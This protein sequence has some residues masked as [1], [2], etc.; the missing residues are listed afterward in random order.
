[1]PRR[2]TMWGSS[3]SIAVSIRVGSKLVDRGCEPRRVAAVLDQRLVLEEGAVERQRPAFAHQPHIGQRLLDAEAAGRAAH[4]EDEVQIAV[5]HFLHAPAAGRAA[6]TRAERGD[7]GEIGG[8]ARHVE[9]PVAVGNG[10][11]AVV[12]AQGSVDLLPSAHPTIV[13]RRPSTEAVPA[14]DTASARRRA[15]CWENRAAQRPGRRDRAGAP[16]RRK[17]RSVARS[18][19][20]SARRLRKINIESTR[21][22]Q[23]A[24]DERDRAAQRPGRRDRAGA[25]PGA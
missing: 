24:G 14:H 18:N 10:D 15:G 16:A 13:D 20:A 2:M 4:Q 7:F 9:G 3:S 25:P 6:E 11:G 17:A 8:K 1:M 12:S 22:P 19:G 21:R 23:G 5:A